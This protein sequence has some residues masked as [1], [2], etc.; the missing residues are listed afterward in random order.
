MSNK[1]TPGPWKATYAAGC[2]WIHQPVDG[3][4]NPDDA[5]T[6][7]RMPGLM[8][9]QTAADAALIAAAPE[10]RAALSDLVDVMKGRMDGETVALHNALA[11]LHK[12]AGAA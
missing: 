5:T 1:H 6:I 7:C 4:G 11:A 9:F 12:S 2:W 10:L 8:E 3:N